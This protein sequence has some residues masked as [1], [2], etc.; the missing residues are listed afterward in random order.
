MLVQKDYW[1]KNSSDKIAQPAMYSC[2]LRQNLVRFMKLR[3]SL[4]LFN[5]GWRNC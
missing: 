3:Q 1:D 5:I 4:H 2:Q